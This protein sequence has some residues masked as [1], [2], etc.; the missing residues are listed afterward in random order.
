[1]P[2]EFYGHKPREC[3][4]HRTVGA[5]AWCLD[6]HEWCSPEA[7]CV[8]CELPALRGR[9][10]VAEEAVGLLRKLRYDLHPV[11]SN[12]AQR[13]H[14]TGG[15]ML[16]PQCHVIIPDREE[17]AVLNRID[18]FLAANRETC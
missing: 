12:T 6:C 9:A 7:P 10:L 13:G 17:Q 11:A 15:Q 3:R 16:T 2:D 8:R 14:G 5:R 4:E 18:I 1:M